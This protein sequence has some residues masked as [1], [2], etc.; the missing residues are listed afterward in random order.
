MYKA[1]VIGL[2]NIGQGYDYDCHDDSLILSH[3]SAYRFHKSFELVCGLDR[4]KSKRDM[5][6]AKYKLPPFCDLDEMMNSQKPEVLSICT[7]TETHFD[8]FNQVISY[9]PRAL[10]IEKPIAASLPEAKKMLVASD[11]KNI[12]CLVNYIRRFEPGTIKL[13]KIINNGLIGDIYKGFVW[14]CKGL[15]NNGSHFIDLLIYL[16]G[17][18]DFIKVLDKGRVNNISGHEDC[19]PDFMLGFGSVKIIFLASK[20]EHFSMGEVT[21]IGTKGSLYYGNGKIQYKNIISDSVY[22]GYKT[23]ENESNI[24]ETDFDK[25][26]YY[27]VDALYKYLLNKIDI[28]SNIKSAIETLKIV[29]NIINQ[30]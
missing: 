15:K 29:E 9:S 13:K 7:P 3:A 1:A 24:I 11:Q 30:R 28:K 5:F 25:Y 23:L 18:V 27:A 16:F 17:S 21:L 26:Q 22:S 8:I 6:R 12:P 10:I 19:E 4:D 14:Y 2:G 20:A